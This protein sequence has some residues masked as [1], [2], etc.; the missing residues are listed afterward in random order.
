MA[1]LTMTSGGTF[2]ESFNF[3]VKKDIEI[4]KEGYA[5]VPKCPVPGMKID[6]DYISKHT[7]ATI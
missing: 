1:G 4:D 6:R 5:H 7:V 3:G 2:Y